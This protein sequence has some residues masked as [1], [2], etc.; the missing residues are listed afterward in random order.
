M[1][2]RNV[3]AYTDLMNDL[4]SYQQQAQSLVDGLHEIDEMMTRVR[5]EMNN[6]RNIQVIRN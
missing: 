4:N 2:R 5:R 1:L 3:E 6:I